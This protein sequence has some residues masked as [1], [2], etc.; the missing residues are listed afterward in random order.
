MLPMI[1]AVVATMLPPVI[2]SAW[3][4]A[5]IKT[6][7]RLPT[8]SPHPYPPPL[9]GLGWGLAL[10]RGSEVAIAG[11]RDRD[12]VTTAIDQPHA[13]AL[14]DGPDRGDREAEFR[15]EATDRLAG[16]GRG[17]EQEL[18]IIARRGEARRQIRLVGD[19]TPRRRG[20]RQRW[21]CDRGANLRRI[22]D[23][24]EIGDQPIRDVEHRVRD[25]GETRSQLDARLGQLKAL[26]E[27]RPVG[28]RESRQA[29]AQHLKPEERVTDRAADP[30]P[31]AWARAAAAE[32]GA[33]S[34]LAERGQ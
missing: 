1:E 15:R 7:R 16:F 9:G 6:V 5:S 19:R 29:T 24:A 2:A 18:V 30:D 32:L 23:M 8:I 33:G 11:G 25:A 34:D 20:Q 31:V 28:R 22:A 27:R 26:G 12:R 14:I 17:G 21:Q 10:R 13:G 3:H 4:R